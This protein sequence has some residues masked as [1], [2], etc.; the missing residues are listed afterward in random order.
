MTAAAIV[1]A[2][3]ATL[4]LIVLFVLYS[5]SR[6]RERLSQKLLRNY[7]FLVNQP[8]QITLFIERV[9]KMSK[10]PQIRSGFY[11]DKLANAF[12]YMHADFSSRY[13]LVGLLAMNFLKDFGPDEKVAP[14]WFQERL[15]ELR[16]ITAHLNELITSQLPEQL[17]ASYNELI[18]KFA[19]SEEQLRAYLLIG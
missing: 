6:E 13:D 17:L 19:R 2:V 18:T 9:E 5:R 16:T 3:V 1:L 15:A 4:T 12:D 8:Q 11:P 10:L 14:A 7:Y